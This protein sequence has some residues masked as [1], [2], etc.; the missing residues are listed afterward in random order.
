MTTPS[1]EFFVTDIYVVG[2]GGYLGSRL[3]PRL[4]ADGLEATPIDALVYGQ[5]GERRDVLDEAPPGDGRP[6]IWLATIHREPP[7]IEQDTE[8]ASAWAEAMWALMVEK[9]FEWFSA[10]HP[11]T[12]VSSMLAVRGDSLYGIAKRAAEQRFVGAPNATV[13]RFGTVWGG[14]GDPPVFPMRVQ[15]AVN[16]YLLGQSLPE[17]YIAFTTHIERALQ[18]LQFAPYYRHLGCVENVLDF[19]EPTKR[20]DLEREL[21]A[22]GEA[23]TMWGHKLAHEARFAE[24]WEGTRDEDVTKALAEYYSLPW[25]TD[26]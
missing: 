9:P 24:Q 15:T 16:R 21:Q 17:D 11:V 14:F 1:K 13:F 2:A 6:V 25:P 12:Y 4:V 10:G 18:T 5:S 3:M 19:D 23:R 8:A 20:D 26:S 22:S 7:G